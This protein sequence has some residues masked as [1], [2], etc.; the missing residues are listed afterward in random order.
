MS[1]LLTLPIA[2]FLRL[3][4]R[5]RGGQVENC[6]GLMQVEGTDVRR[7]AVWEGGQRFTT[8]GIQRDLELFEISEDN[9]QII[10][11]SRTDDSVNSALIENRQPNSNEF[12][13][14]TFAVTFGSKNGTVPEPF[15]ST[16]GNAI[17]QAT[18][19]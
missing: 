19:D 5:K 16:I 6:E 2:Y 12:R 3:R 8:I 7:H 18:V 1:L 9:R 4:A 14:R 10:F 13:A 15:T 11:H 17:E